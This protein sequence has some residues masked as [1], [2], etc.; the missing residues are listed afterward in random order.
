MVATYIP[1]KISM[2]VCRKNKMNR[3]NTDIWVRP[4]RHKDREGTNVFS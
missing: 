2:I 1:A 3:A 4:D